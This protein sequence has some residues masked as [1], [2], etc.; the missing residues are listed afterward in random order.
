MPQD[1]SAQLTSLVI[2]Y[3]HQKDDD[4]AAMVIEQLSPFTK[5]EANRLSQQ[6]FGLAPFDDLYSV[7]IQQC[8]L[9]MTKYDISSGPFLQYAMRSI[10]GAMLHYMRD[11]TIEVQISGSVKESMYAINR[12]ID[13]H[14]KEHGH[15]PSVS[16]IA[17]ALNYSYKR[18][19]D[20]MAVTSYVKM[21][22][23]IDDCEHA[24]SVGILGQI[25]DDDNIDTK[26]GKELVEEV[27]R[28]RKSGKDVDDFM[29][30]YGL[31]RDSA[32]ELVGII[33]SH[34]LHTITI[35]GGDSIFDVIGAL[36]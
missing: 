34:F 36:L 15:Q 13:K 3:K 6:S 24:V 27:V 28:L 7:G 21:P 22:K 8:F 12:F 16:Q 25:E 2:R 5:R 33:D 30:L 35:P 32:V 26:D 31:D 11:H 4:V 18:V 29:L 17:T 9:C 20:A 23:C 10:R 14:E 1:R 19:E